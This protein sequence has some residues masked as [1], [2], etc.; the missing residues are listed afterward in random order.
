MT[1][2]FIQIVLKNFNKKGAK[3]SSGEKTIT[4]LT[5]KASEA[6]KEALESAKNKAEK[7]LSEE[8]VNFISTMHNIVFTCLNKLP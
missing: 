8:E 6:L 7:R 4:E 5:E 1:R 3:M 2:V